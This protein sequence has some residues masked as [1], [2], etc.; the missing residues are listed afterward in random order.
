[1]FFG[2]SVFTFLP[3]LV[4]GALFNHF[5]RA[6]AFKEL[7]RALSLG[8]RDKKE[9]LARMRRAGGVD[10]PA[11]LRAGLS[12]TLLLEVRAVVVPLLFPNRFFR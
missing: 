2:V 11:A 12:W 8:T 9:V 6:K 10:K 5:Y 4:N 1:M 7:K 3:V